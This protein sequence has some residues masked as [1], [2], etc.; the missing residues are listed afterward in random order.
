MRL[1]TSLVL[2]FIVIDVTCGTLNSVFS[3]ST[4]DVIPDRKIDAIYVGTTTLATH[5]RSTLT[6][7]GCAGICED[8]PGCGGFNFCELSED[9]TC[10]AVA[11]S[12]APLDMSSLRWAVG[13][14][15]FHKALVSSSLA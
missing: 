15:Y 12:Q 10:E 1:T 9:R 3:T 11:T 8:A 4:Y 13:C 6:I 2:F 7:V 14:F 5:N